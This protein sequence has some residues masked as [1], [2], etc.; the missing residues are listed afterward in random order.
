ML[1]N[2]AQV[3]TAFIEDRADHLVVGR[4]VLELGAG[5]G[6]PSLVC[7][8]YGASKVVVT[9]YPEAKLVANLRYNIEHC[10]LLENKENIVAEG[11]LWGNPIESLQRHISSDTKGFDVLILADILFNHSEHKKLI[12]TLKDA[13]K[14]QPDSVALVFFTPYRPW[15]LEK[16]LRFFELAKESGL[17]VTKILEHTMDKVMFENDPGDERLRRTVF[18]YEVRWSL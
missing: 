3:I 5:A 1:W 18:G 13:M 15:L 16:D 6:L 11:Y 12:G 8:I 9:D 4:T 2:A 17:S 10:D 7:T 14:P